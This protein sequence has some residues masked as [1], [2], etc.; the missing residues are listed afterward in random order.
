MPSNVARFEQLMYLAIAFGVIEAA[1]NWNRAVLEADPVGGATFVVI[2]QGSILL[3]DVILIWLIARRRKNWARWLALISFL[4]EIPFR[5]NTYIDL[6]QTDAFA[7]V[8]SA[9]QD[10]LQM[11][12]LYLV[13]TG[14]A[15]DWFQHP[16]TDSI[17]R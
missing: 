3:S 13:F 6:F 8:L 4:V 7:G 12:A 11:I 16:A 2:V 9:A 5:V 14:D 1:L 15:R 17:P 10:L